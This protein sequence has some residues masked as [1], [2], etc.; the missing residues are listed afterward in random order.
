MERPRPPDAEIVEKKI[1]NMTVT[2]SNLAI[3]TWYA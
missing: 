2:N 1:D 3:E